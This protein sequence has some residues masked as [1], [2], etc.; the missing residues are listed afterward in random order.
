[1]TKTS[2]KAAR[3]TLPARIRNKQKSSGDFA[4]RMALIDRIADLPG[5]ETVERNDEDIPG[6]VEIYFRRETSDRVLKRKPARQ[7]CCLDCNCVTVSGLSRWD[8]YQVLRNGWGKLVNDQVCVYLPRDHEEL[9]IVWSVIR[10]AYCRFTGPPNPESGSVIVS[11]WDFPRF[12]RT[13]L[14]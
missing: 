3:L 11:T 5:I 14:Q 4:A 13:S 7:L 6:R 12:S 9:E 10:Q 1:M 8:T 2:K